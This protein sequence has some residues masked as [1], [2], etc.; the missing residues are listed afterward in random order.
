MSLLRQLLFTLLYHQCR[1]DEIDITLDTIDDE[2]ARL[3]IEYEGHTLTADR[4]SYLLYNRSVW[5]SDDSDIFISYDGWTNHWELL[6][7]STSHLPNVYRVE[8]VDLI[9]PSTVWTNKWTQN[10]LHMTYDCNPS[11]PPSSTPSSVPSYSVLDEYTQTFQCVV[12]HL[13]SS[14]K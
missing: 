1:A 7:P 9:P 8:S 6:L 13:F 2:C 5:S 12:V 3:S 4:Q 14:K 10:Q 11:L